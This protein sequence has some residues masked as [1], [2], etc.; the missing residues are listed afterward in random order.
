MWID[1]QADSKRESLNCTLVAVWTILWGISS[2]FPLANHFLFALFTV[3]IWAISRWSHV[4]SP[5]LAKVDT[6]AK[7]C[8]QLSITWHPFLFDL[9]GALL[10]MC[11]WRGL[12][13]QEWA[14]CGLG[15]AQPP[16]SIVLLSSSHLFILFM[17]FSKQECW[18]GQPFP[19]PVDHVLSGK[20]TRSS[21]MT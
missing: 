13:L 18:N 11:G 1:T 16:L 15:R 6:T 8:G 14:I 3:H 7:A 4:C 21:G 20:T 9:Q 19:S 12:L 10:R 17:G 5:L 2:R